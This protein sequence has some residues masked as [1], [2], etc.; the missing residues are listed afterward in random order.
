MVRKKDLSKVL[1]SLSDC[2]DAANTRLSRGRAVGRSYLALEE[3]VRR[4]PIGND[5]R[6][7]NDSKVCVR[8]G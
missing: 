3:K 2:A 6:S 4:I 1:F 5:G 8:G 7:K